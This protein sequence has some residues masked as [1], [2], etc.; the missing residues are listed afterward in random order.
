MKK[1]FTLKM[2]GKGIYEV[3][4]VKGLDALD[5]DLRRMGED[6][7]TQ[8]GHYAVTA[9]MGPVAGDVKTNLMTGR[10]SEQRAKKGGQGIYDTGALARS[11]QVYPKTYKQQISKSNSR[12]RGGRRVIADVRAGV[13]GKPGINKRGPNKGNRKPVYALQVEYGTENSA[14]G[15]LAPQP[16]MRPA[17]DGKERAIAYRLR[18]LLRNQIIKWQYTGK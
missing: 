15:S 6:L 8:K 9:S 2:R 14:F 18:T 12:A 17:F 7:A 10:H 1:D 3:F 5:R 16:F 11:V 4:E 13:G